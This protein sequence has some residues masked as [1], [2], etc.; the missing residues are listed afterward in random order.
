MGWVEVMRL[1]EDVD[2]RRALEKARG[3][4]ELD[5]VEHLARVGEGRL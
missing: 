5:A 4:I 2:R 1:R 3:P